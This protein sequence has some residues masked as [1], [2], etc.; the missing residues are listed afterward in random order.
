MTLE[1][2]LAKRGWARDEFN[3]WLT[4]ADKIVTRA[5]GP[6]ALSWDIAIMVMSA[7]HQVQKKDAA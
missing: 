1:E 6:R 3:H 7:K 4:E 5:P 2:M